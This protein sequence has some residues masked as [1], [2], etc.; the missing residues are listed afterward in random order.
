L[1]S[2][3]YLSFHLTHYMLMHYLRKLKHIKSA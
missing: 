1:P 3:G 2:N